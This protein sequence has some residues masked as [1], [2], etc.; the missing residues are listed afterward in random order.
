VFTFAWCNYHCFLKACVIFI[1]CC[2]LCYFGVNS[3]TTIFLGKLASSS[4][5]VMFCATLCVMNETIIVSLKLTSSSFFVVFYI[6][7]HCVFIVIFTLH[8]SRFVFFSPSLFFICFLNF[9]VFL[10]SFGKVSL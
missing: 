4:F 10:C 1:S 7:C 3:T 8:C 9:I 5:L 6:L 2:V